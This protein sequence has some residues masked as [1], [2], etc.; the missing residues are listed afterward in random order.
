MATQL[1]LFMTKWALLGVLV[2]PTAAVSQAASGLIPVDGGRLYYE[3]LGSGPAV[4]LLH[5]GTTHSIVWDNQFSRLS[6]RWR[7]VRYDRRGY[8][9]SAKPDTSYSNAADLHHLL[10]ELAI[11]R[12][13]LVGASAGGR[14]AVEFA[15]EH[16]ERVAG[17]VLVGAV[18]GGVPV[19]QHFHEVAWSRVQPVLTPDRTAVL[20][21]LP[22]SA[23]DEMARRYAE[24]PYLIEPS[25]ERAKEWLR[26]AVREHYSNVL[27]PA[28]WMIWLEPP[29]QRRLSEVDLPTLIVVG[30]GDHPDL[31]ANAGA[32][33]VGIRDSNRVVIEGAAHFPQVEQPEAFN[34]LLVKFLEERAAW[35]LSGAANV[36]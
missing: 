30:E 2:W 25:N 27:N 13:V 5:D 22:Q 29:A 28:R 14:L 21:P 33:Q 24:D 7:L 19:S 12:A 34:S 26:Q 16:P 9:R 10:D 20:E 4:V 18:T 1:K 15:I 6:S 11:D 3:S 32:F 8:G 31:H 35:S 23:I 36:R 17:L